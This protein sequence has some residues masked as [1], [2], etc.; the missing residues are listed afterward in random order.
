MLFVF[1]STV[2]LPIGSEAIRKRGVWNGQ[3]RKVLCCSYILYI[4]N[5]LCLRL[6]EQRAETLEHDAHV[7]P[8][9]PVAAVPDIGLCAVLAL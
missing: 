4:M 1:D 5:R 8:E 3:F 6:A 7:E 9:P 2:C